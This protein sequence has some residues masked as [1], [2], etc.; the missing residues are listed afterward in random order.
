[1]HRNPYWYVFL[2]SIG[3]IVLGYTGFTF[4]QVYRHARLS[5]HA[6]PLSLKWS[7]NKIDEDDYALQANYEFNWEGKAYS[8]Y[9]PNIDHYLNN[10]AAKDALDRANKRTFQIW[11]DP[12]D[13]QK[14]TLFKIFPLKYCIYT[15]ILWLLFLYFI[16]LGYSMNRY[17]A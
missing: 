17:R 14:S 5:Q 11:F 12:A 7:I 4:V 6:E 10:L 8:G 1:M 13:P 16:R 15:G 2:L 9:I 3:L